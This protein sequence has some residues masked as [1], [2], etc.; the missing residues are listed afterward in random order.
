M[1][2]LL[3]EELRE[4]THPVL[5]VLILAHDVVH[6]VVVVVVVAAAAAVIVLL[7]HTIIAV[8]VVVVVVAHAAATR[9]QVDRRENFGSGGERE[10]EHAAERMH[11]PRGRLRLSD[12]RRER[13]AREQLHCEGFKERPVAV[14]WGRRSQGGAHLAASEGGAVAT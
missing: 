2:N 8:V 7:L 14:G 10:G 5:A 13:P 4:T 3:L 12:Q 11:Q 1:R 9:R 6:V